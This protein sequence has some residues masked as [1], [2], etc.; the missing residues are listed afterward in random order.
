MFPQYD[1]KRTGYFLL[2]DTIGEFLAKHL[3]A[4]PSWLKLVIT[5]RSDKMNVATRGLPFHHINLDKSIIDERIR[6]DILDYITIRIQESPIISSNITPLSPSHGGCERKG[7]TSTNKSP[8][9]S[10]QHPY[11]SPEDQQNNPLA[12]AQARFTQ[13]LTDASKG[14]FLFAKLVL[15]LITKGH[16]IIKSSSSFKVLPISLAQVFL[17]ECNLRFSSIKSFE[18]ASDILSICAA[19]LTPMNC[20]QIFHTLNALRPEKSTWPEFV[21]R[22]KLHNI[23]ILYL[24][25]CVLI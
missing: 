5:V 7:V 18:K 15:D 16:L 17:L 2:G 1:I 6:K 24:Q 10:P 11:I 13:H 9:L 21:S 3:Q 4:F 14:C 8:S 12:S 22:Y 23:I 20:N 25:P 19:S